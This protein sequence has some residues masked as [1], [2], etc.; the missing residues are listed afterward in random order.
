MSFTY[1]QSL[2]EEVFNSCYRERERERERAINVT[3]QTQKGPKH[4]KR[5][6]K[7]ETVGD[8]SFLFHMIRVYNYTEISTLQVKA[9]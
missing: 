4:E 1:G 6:I 5:T 9:Q 8:F 2:R 3:P 7:R